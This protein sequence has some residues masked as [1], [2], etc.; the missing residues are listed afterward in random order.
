MK[1]IT[2]NPRTTAQNRK[3]YWLF[4]QLNIHDADAIAEIVWSHTNHRTQHTSE[5]SFME[6][7]ELIKW[8]ESTLKGSRLSK[9]ELVDAGNNDKE[10]DNLDR[11]RK[12]L[13]RAIFRWFEL[14]G[15]IVTMDY[16]KGVACRAAGVERF[17]AISPDALTRLYHEF[18]RKQKTQ[19]TIQEDYFI[20]YPN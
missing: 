11:K 20:I 9:A 18:C 17:N 7:M 19:E 10:K 12:G 1:Q 6:C 4:G 13:I 2:Q 5:L 3:L 15:K 14:Q 16:V 8:L